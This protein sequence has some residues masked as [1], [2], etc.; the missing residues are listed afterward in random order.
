LVASR[1]T[2]LQRLGRLPM[3]LRL[4]SNRQLCVGA[5]QAGFEKLPTAVACKNPS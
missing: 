2:W 4:I 5:P 3:L 1:F